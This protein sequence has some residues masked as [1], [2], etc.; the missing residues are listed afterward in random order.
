MDVLLTAL[1]GTERCMSTGSFSSRGFLL[2][3]AT[4]FA[5]KHNP[6]EVIGK[7]LAGVTG[8]YALEMVTYVITVCNGVCLTILVY[9][10]DLKSRSLRE[11]CLA[12][13]CREILRVSK[14]YAA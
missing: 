14:M 13:M 12:Y 2:D 4:Y 7:Q 5:V 8:V 6:V 9:D 11:D 10:A 1:Y 3:M